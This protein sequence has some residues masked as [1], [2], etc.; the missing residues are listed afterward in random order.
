MLADL[1][2][3]GYIDKEENFVCPLHGW[4]FD[5]STGKCLNNE[6]ACLKIEELTND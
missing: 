4:K 3:I 1:E 5:L 2:E 6:N